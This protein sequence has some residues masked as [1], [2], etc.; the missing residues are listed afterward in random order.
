[1]NNYNPYAVNPTAYQN[2][3]QQV[4]LT[5]DQRVKLQRAAYGFTQN[6]SNVYQQYQNMTP[7]IYGVI[8][9]YKY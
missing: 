9:Q 2:H 7:S 1:M 6:Q 4:F 5:Q 8:K 3:N